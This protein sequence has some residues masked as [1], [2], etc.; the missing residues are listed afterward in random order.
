[1]T[2][3]LATVFFFFLLAPL[4]AAGQTNLS[5]TIA[6]DSTLT[7]AG[8]P[9]IVSGGAL[10]VQ[11]PHTLTIDSGVVVRFQS[12]CFLE[13]SGNLHAR[14]ATFT[15]NADTVGGTPTAGYWYGI[16]IGR[17]SVTATALL[18]TCQIQFAGEGSY[19][20]V[21]ISNG[22]VTIAGGLVSNAGSACAHL[23]S[24]TLTVAN[25]ALSLA[26]NA[27][28]MVD[29]G[30][31]NFTSSSISNCL[32]PIMYDG[33][34]S[35]VFNGTNSFTLNTNNEIYLNFN[36]AGSMVLDTAS[37]PYVIAGG[38]NV[39]N[40]STF[41]MSPGIFILNGSFSVN[42]SSK[43]KIQPGSILKMYS[44]SRMYV[45]GSLSAVGTA[46]QNIYFTSWRDDN[47][48]GDTNGDGTA[49]SPAVNDW[50]GVVFADES[51]DSLCVMRNCSV[52]FAGSGN[53]GGITMYN[54]SPTIDS[55]KM[56]NNYYGAM[57]QGTSSPVFTNNTIGSS[58]LVPIA[59]SFSANPVFNN[60]AF[61]FSDN[62]Y[63]AIGLIGETLPANAVLPIR[64]VTTSPNVTYLL[65]G[66]VVVQ[67]GNT[68]T[69]NKGIVI[70]GSFYD[71]HIAVQGKL[72]A[73][74][75]QDSMIVMT[76]SKDDNYGNPH[77]TN[78]D[79]NATTPQVG[80]WSGIVFEPGSDSAS[81]LNYCRVTYASMQPYYIYQYNNT[82]YYTGEVTTLNASPT[83]SNCQIGNSVY[84]IYAAL[85][86]KPK[87]LNTSIFNSQYT[88]IAMSVSAN[89]VFSG[90]TFTNTGWTALGLIGEN[91]ALNA[92]LKQRTVGGYSNITYVLLGD[93]TINSGTYVTVDAGIV[94]KSGG[95]GAYNGSTGPGIYVNGGFQAKG[96]V[97]GGQIVFTSLKDDNYGHPNDTNGDGAA[98]SPSGGDW[99]TIRFQATSDDAFCIMDSCLVKFGGY[100]NWGLVTFTD[101][102]GTLSHSNLS[103]SYSFGVRCEN[104]STPTVNGVSIANC[105]LDPIGMS[106]LSNPVF[107]NI[108][109]TANGSNGIRIL[110]G[111]LSSNANLASR[112]I[113]GIT[114]VAYIIDQLTVGP[115]AVL[116]IQ[117]GV[118]IKFLL[119]PYGYSHVI[120]VQGALKADGTA[121]QPIIF[122]SI[123]DDSYGGD[124]NNDGNSS[125]PGRGDW[126]SVDFTAS[127][128]DSL[129]S[130]TNCDFRYGG[131]QYWWDGATYEW[132]LVRVFDAQVNI[133]HCTFEQ[134]STAGLGIFGSAHPA[135]L[136]SNIYNIAST[137]IVMS[138][139]SNP[140]FVSDTALNVG[141]MALGIVPETYSVNASVA[142]RNFGGYTNITYYLYSTCT[143]NTGTTIAIPAG[144]VFKGGSWVVNGGL[145]VQGS[146]SQ[147]VVFT[148]PADDAYGHPGD[149]NGDG[150]ATQ[151]SIQSSLNRVTFNDVSID[152][153]STL[154]HAVFRYSDGGIYLQQ[155]APVINNCTFDHDNWGVYLSGVSTPALD[156]CSFSNL[157]FAPFQTSLVSY[158]RSTLSNSISGTTYKAIG[159]MNETLA[160]D[161][162]LQNRDFGGIHHIPYFFNNYTIASNAI[163]T[164]A[165][166][167]VLKFAPLTGITVNKGLIAAGGSTVDSTIVF[168]DIRDNFYGGD[169]NADSTATKPSDYWWLGNCCGY[170]GWNGIT[171][172][173]QSLDPLCRLSHCVI[174]YAGIQMNWY[175]SIWMYGAGIWTNNASPSITYCS[176]TGNGIGVVAWGAS[177]PTVNYCDIYNNLQYGIDNV[178]QSFNVD[179]RWNWWGSNTGPTHSG[180][181]G[182]TGQA[183]TDSVNYTPFFS[184]GSMN[185]LLGNVSLNGVVQAYDASLI[186][187]FVVDSVGNPLSPVQ[188]RV[189]DVSGAMGITAYDASL[190][191]Q[192]VVGNILS[193]PADTAPKNTPLVL[194]KVV[195]AGIGIQNASTARGTEIVVPIRVNH[196]QNLAS[197]DIRLTFDDKLLT[198]KEVRFAPGV[199]S[200]TSFSKISKGQIIIAMAGGTPC[201]V[202]GDLA[203]LTLNVSKDVRGTVKSTISFSRLLLN[204]KNFNS[205]SSAGQLTII[206]KPTQ[207]ALN[208]NYPNPFNPTTTISYQLPDDN[209]LVRLV[210][211]NF[212]G[213]MVRTLV[214]GLQDAGVYSVTWDGRNDRGI[215]V[216]SGVYLY[217]ISTDKFAQVK[218]LMMM[219]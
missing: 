17:Y 152:S 118:V 67:P 59:M 93:I 174:K 61:S 147:P 199:S 181:P 167:V 129:N 98:T 109:F 22:N 88:P 65:L 73:Q 133:N 176:L 185:P 72:V 46:T 37:I 80:D 193:F 165:P 153:L 139:F 68:L 164:I 136:N 27:G 204:E 151:P 210:V 18:D 76:L 132:A 9:Y 106:L 51:R 126:A 102:G 146:S 198:A 211:Y 92:E 62:Q 196:L 107:T 197:V 201:N 49:T 94:V 74:G 144:A 131:P 3:R 19:G 82:Y 183:V 173:D 130:I 12:S 31:V 45:Y 113:A 44:G 128:L 127:S 57:I 163:L 213:Q 209:T 36:Y 5:G 2:K 187:K 207:Y 112:N 21:D 14:W 180:N 105:R 6:T 7:L 161:V 41:T 89:P 63:D 40:G 178:N 1:M 29:G 69:I 134:S 64:S 91:V 16:L 30:T 122:T 186:L 155:A 170:A 188:E 25:S 101:A 168:T 103:D 124:T 104:S 157:T 143:I 141:Y 158:P 42:D 26:P 189:A 216:S 90:I 179:A 206:G 108:T 32:W 114:N 169:T 149:T 182:G 99:S 116:T 219:K 39:S 205:S 85:S 53:I 177:N 171:F 191:L 135:V 95:P 115:S 50:G 120:T 48:G 214:D 148:D 77:D 56:A 172:A 47:L 71:Q 23:R 175:N 87:I 111:T 117:P 119:S 13:L 60:N 11:S 150:S 202:D 15:S 140:S 10:T 217:R 160:Q 162:T 96:T 137:P 54:A 38:F 194:P 52:A 28:L 142:L 208:Q 83:I 212:N 97:A 121:T 215:P 43:L 4:M 75:T 70:K 166:G 156:S 145:A 154:H 78:K 84:G 195:A 123:K 138:M 218:K 159:V 20:N 24:G 190:I 35:L 86:S 55:C 203:Y 81:I 79:G 66:T 58:Q 33:T 184:T 8:S 110:E 100:N 125:T 192:Y 34:A 200:M